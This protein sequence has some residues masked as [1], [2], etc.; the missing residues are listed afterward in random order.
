MSATTTALRSVNSSE[1]SRNSAKVFAAAEVR[2]VDVT[3]RDGDDL[4]L[5]SKRESDARA[6]LL[7]LAAQMIA[8]ATDER[9]TLAD[10]MADHF[11][12]MLALSTA[13]R[14]SCARELLESARASFA[15]GE[16]YLAVAAMI[17][18]RET[19]TAIASGLHATPVEW[20]A[21]DITVER[22]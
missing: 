18:W 4:V 14:A 17:S 13:D 9:G 11:P 20:L 6:E 16:A 10:R 21:E 19:A 15:T 22:P 2:P 1:L 3:R 5:M 7:N 12:W 8:V